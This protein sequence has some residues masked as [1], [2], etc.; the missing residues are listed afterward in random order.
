MLSAVS[1]GPSS[2]GTIRL[3]TLPSPGYIRSARPT[4]WTGSGINARSSAQ[5]TEPHT[6]TRMAH[7]VCG[8]GE[9]PPNLDSNSRAACRARRCSRLRQA[10]EFPA[11]EITS[12]QYLG[13]SGS[14]LDDH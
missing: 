2:T 13:A 5:Y 4:A 3:A 1:L 11:S 9:L 6:V 10:G 14:A 7:T 12:A 8:P